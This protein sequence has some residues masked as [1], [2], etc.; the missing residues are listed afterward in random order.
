MVRTDPPVQDGGRGISADEPDSDPAQPPA[1]TSSRFERNLAASFPLIFL[2]VGCLA[3]GVILWLE[4][5]RATIG[6]IPIWLPFLAIGIIAVAG[7]TLSLFAEP[8]PVPGE[9]SEPPSRRTPAR[10]GPTESRPRRPAPLPP[11]RPRGEIGRPAPVLR[12]RASSPPVETEASV[13]PASGTTS[14]SSPV[15]GP[16]EPLDSDAGALL[17]EIDAI[18]AAIHGS[19]ASAPARPAPVQRTGG[20]ALTASPAGTA[21]AVSGPV[22]ADPSG[23]AAPAAE[24]PRT[25]DHCVGCGSTILHSGSPVRCQV[26]GEP[27]CTDCRDRSLAEGKPNLCP[28][29]GLLDSVHSKGTPTG[30]PARSTH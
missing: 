28:L 29:C 3:I 14:A 30:A 7:A 4:K 13:G 24:S 1:D 17:A 22:G 18:D 16:S 20:S 5:T 26:C 11:A 9:S 8:D 12:A 10:D 19:R 2:G 21:P 27:L 15:P 6:H 23:M 25:R